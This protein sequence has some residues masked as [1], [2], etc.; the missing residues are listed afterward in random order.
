VFGGTPGF[1]DVV[2]TVLRTADADAIRDELEGAS[3]GPLGEKRE[4]YYE[5]IVASRLYNA[6]PAH[7]RDAAS[8]LAVSELP[9]PV[10]AVAE[11]IGVEVD[12]TE[13]ILTSCVAFGMIQKFGE[14][15]ETPLY[16]PPG[17]LRPWLSDPTRLPDATARAVDRQL[18]AFWRASYDADREAELRVPIDVALAACRLHARRGGDRATFRWATVRLARRLER[19]TEWIAARDLFN[20]S[21]DDDHDA[22]SLRALAS[23][24][25]A[26]GEW[27]A[28][29]RHLD[30][31]LELPSEDRAGEAATRHQLATI[32]L[33]EG[34]LD[35]ARAGFARAL[36]IVQE[37]GD[38]AGEAATF[39]QLGALAH[40]LGR[41][42]EGA[43]LIAICCLIEQAIGDV[44]LETNLQTLTA[45]CQHL[46]FDQAEFDAMM[47]KAR[48]EYALDRGLSAIAAAF[49]DL[50]PGGRGPEA[51]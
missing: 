46:G 48:Q 22:E 15:D 16:H 40:V 51:S 10:D 50:P 2:R 47:D 18:A 45:F 30:K 3:S 36:A 7:G 34:K 9:L 31:A 20:E 29:R 49:A 35:D 38:R 28:A 23:L 13:A 21:A 39:Y 6:L 37:V 27:K 33:N 19:R 8:R 25:I 41:S 5:K 32:D 4:S 26:L 14:A 24:E 17:L 43:L 42:R 1:L 12:E 11:I 44:E